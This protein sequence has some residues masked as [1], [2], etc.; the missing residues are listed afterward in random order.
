[1]Y[2]ERW[3]TSRNLTATSNEQTTANLR[4]SGGRDEMARPVP[5]A[6]LG[7]L[8]RQRE[9]S[10]RQQR[11]EQQLRKQEPGQRLAAPGHGGAGPRR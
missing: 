8:V 10:I 5:A 4:G 7:A 11:V 1:V 6:P 9:Q 2:A 3:S